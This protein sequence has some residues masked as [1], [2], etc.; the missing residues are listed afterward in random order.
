MD[1]NSGFMLRL[2]LC[3][4]CFS[5]RLLINQ[6]CEPNE[7]L[8]KGG[9]SIDEI[10]QCRNVCSSSEKYKFRVSLPTFLLETTW[11]DFLYPVGYLRKLLSDKLTPEN[12]TQNKKTPSVE[13]HPIDKTQ[14]N[15]HGRGLKARTV[16][17]SRF[18]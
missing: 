1:V 8:L 4:G 9:N 13:L 18:P 6:M 11:M 15:L 3:F 12:E 7:R 5:M 17:T 16:G 2:N 14:E 10:G